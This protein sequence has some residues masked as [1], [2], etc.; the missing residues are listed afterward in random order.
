MGKCVY[1]KECNEDSKGKWMIMLK[2][3]ETLE[4]VQGGREMSRERVLGF[5]K[6]EERDKSRG[7]I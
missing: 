3:R 4:E 7:L 2:G 5:R 6:V 1:A